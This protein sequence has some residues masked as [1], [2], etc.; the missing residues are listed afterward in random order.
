MDIRPAQP[1]DL[2]IAKAWLQSAGLP[3]A[4]LTDAHMPHF[5]IA[6]AGD[7][8]VGMIG[9]EEYANCGLLRSLIVDESC[10]GS[11]VGERLV[12]ALEARTASRGMQSLWLLTID[13]DA[14]FS[15]LGYAEMPRQ[16]APQAI[17]NSAEFSSLCP[18][19]AVLM[20]KQLTSA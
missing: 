18:G 9:V 10:R 14:Y 6:S 8:S 12:A 17:Q 7:A 4:D 16:E 13:A 1:A 2:A 3:T 11:G 19:N 15:R 20:R 5:L